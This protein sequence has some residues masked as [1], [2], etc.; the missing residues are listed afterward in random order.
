MSKKYVSRK[1]EQRKISCQKKKKM[2][3]F[4]SFVSKCLEKKFDILIV[5][6]KVKIVTNTPQTE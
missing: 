1:H 6:V 2:Q 4:F 5:G 3:L